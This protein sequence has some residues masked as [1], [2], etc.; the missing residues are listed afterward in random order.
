MNL[1]SPRG[2]SIPFILDIPNIPN[3]PVASESVQNP[4]N[5]QSE[6]IPDFSERDK[7]HKKAAKLG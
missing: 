5:I 2:L 4:L 1:D 3:I 7:L 6:S